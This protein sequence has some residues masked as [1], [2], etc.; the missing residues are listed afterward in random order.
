MDG[1]VGKCV[2]TVDVERVLP[3]ASAQEKRLRF[4]WEQKPT[5][6]FLM[7]WNQYMEPNSIFVEDVNDEGITVTV[8]W[9][10]MQETPEQIAARLNHWLEQVEDGK[11]RRSGI[12][13]RHL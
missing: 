12:S 9:A 1:K 7:A 11:F 3:V 8:R 5:E 13:G 10:L 4:E 2:E 6:K